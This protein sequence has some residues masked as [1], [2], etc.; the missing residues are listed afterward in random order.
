MRQRHPESRMS[1]V[2]MVLA[3]LNLA[4]AVIAA[5]AGGARYATMITFE[6]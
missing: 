5:C 4:S 1:H 2:L 3:M 6:Q